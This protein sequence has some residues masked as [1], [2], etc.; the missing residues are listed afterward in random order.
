MQT[1]EEALDK[2][3]TSRFRAGSL[4]LVLLLARMFP[5][6]STRMAEG[7]AFAQISHS[8]TL[9]SQMQKLYHWSYP[10]S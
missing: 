2:L 8:G 6:L 9:K 7:V 4:T 10:R 1:I 3:E 5:L